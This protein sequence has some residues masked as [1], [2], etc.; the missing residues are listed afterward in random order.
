MGD[1]NEAAPG[2]FQ[3]EKKA[4]HNAWASV[5]GTKKEDAQKQYITLAEGLISK[6]G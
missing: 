3:M 6:Y 2:V 1:N 4:K 5:K